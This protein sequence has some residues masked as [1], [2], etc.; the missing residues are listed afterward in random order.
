VKAYIVKYWATQ[1]IFP[2]EGEIQD[3]G[4]F[5]A[6]RDGYYHCFSPGDWASSTNEALEMAKDLRSKKLVNM[7]KLAT[8]LAN[9]EIQITP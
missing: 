9:M 6:C 2:M 7:A 1:G 8:K 3:S 4:R 5:M